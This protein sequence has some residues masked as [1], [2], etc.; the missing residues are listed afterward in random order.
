MRAVFPLFLGLLLSLNACGFRS[1]KNNIPGS[2][3]QNDQ[4][5]ADAR[6]IKNATE[7]SE[8][9]K[10]DTQTILDSKPLVK[11]LVIY[12]IEPAEISNHVPFR[13]KLPALGDPNA[14]LELKVLAYFDPK[15]ITINS[16]PIALNQG[17]FLDRSGFI[18]PGTRFLDLHYNEFQKIP[19][20]SLSNAWFKNHAIDSDAMKFEWFIC[21]CNQSDESA[22][23]T[24][25]NSMINRGLIHFKHPEKSTHIHPSF[26]ALLPKQK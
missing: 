23:M 4:H 19:L 2:L 8:K 24:L 3:M 15:D 10:K 17:Y 1:K 7:F 26:G 11:P 14:D 5:T 25:L 9:I 13:T 20:D 21:D 12:K 22:N 18:G 16:T 6:P